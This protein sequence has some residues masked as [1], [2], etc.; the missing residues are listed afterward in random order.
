MRLLWACH[1]AHGS[2]PSFGNRAELPSACVS[3]YA[4]KALILISLFMHL[5]SLPHVSDACEK[6]HETTGSVL[7]N[8][9]P[10]RLLGL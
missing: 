3:P 9:K 10:T 6:Y 1:I 5:P 8:L 2:R 4:A 7:F